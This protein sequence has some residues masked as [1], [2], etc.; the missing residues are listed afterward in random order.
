MKTLKIFLSPEQSITAHGNVGK[1][2]AR[3]KGNVYEDL[4]EQLEFLRDN[5]SMPFA[6]R[7]V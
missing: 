5:Y 2:N 7:I 4:Q 1:V 6:T 3:K